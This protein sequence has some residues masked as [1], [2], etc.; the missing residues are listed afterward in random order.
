METVTQMWK[1]H[2]GAL[3]NSSNYCAIG[4]SL[5]QNINHQKHFKG[6]IDFTCKRY[7]IKPLLRN[8]L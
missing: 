4:N 3:L 6:I 8:K 2:F 1:N 5:K 7:K